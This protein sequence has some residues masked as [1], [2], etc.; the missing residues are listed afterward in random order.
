M[1]NATANQNVAPKF[2]W[3]KEELRAMTMAELLENFDRVTARIMEIV[4]KVV[5]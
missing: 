4:P 2:E 5:F 3:T 1:R